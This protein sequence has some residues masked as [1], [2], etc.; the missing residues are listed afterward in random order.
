RAGVSFGGAMIVMNPDYEKGQTSSL[1]AGLRALPAGAE[2][3]L[4]FPADHPLITE[5]EIKPLVDEYIR[6][7]AE[8]QIFIPSYN[9]KRG[10]PVLFDAA[11]KEEFLTLPPDTPART[12]VDLHPGRIAY[13][14]IPTA[15]ILMDMD[16]PEDYARCLEEWG[17]RETT[18]RRAAEGHS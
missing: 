12:V 16:T 6:R 4:L 10:H 8:R 9:L 5:N 15:A 3:F 14:E 1:Q 18:R 13:V 2:G 11:L 7:K 17:R